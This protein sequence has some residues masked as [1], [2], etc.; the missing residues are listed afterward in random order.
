MSHDARLKVVF[1]GTPDF[2]V[3]VLGALVEAGHDVAGVYTQPDRRAGRGRSSAASPVKRY[4]LAHGLPVLQPASLR[5]DEQA[6]TTLGA[7]APDVVVVAAYGLF[8]PTAMLETP[9]LGCLNIH[10][11]LLPRRRGPSPV[12]SAILEGDATTGVTVI[13]LDDRMD[14]GPIIAQR[15]TPICPHETAGA[16]TA[17]LFRLGAELLL[18]RLPG[19]DRGV[20]VPVD[21]DESLATDTSRLVKQ[22]GE[23][24]WGRPAEYIARQVRAYDPWPGDVHSMG[25]Q[26]PG[27]R[28][29][30]RRTRASR[31]GP[32]R[33]GD[34]VWERGR[35][36]HR[37]GC[38]RAPDGADR[39]SEARYRRRFRQGP[40]RLRR[41]GPRG[42]IGAL[43]P[44]R[45]VPAHAASLVSWQRS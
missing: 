31:I 33:S 1:M 22:D 2:A 35:R 32:C 29:G 24:D 9:R 23:I 4:A 30:L 16:L 45:G 34:G 18:E 27:R 43:A 7:L 42:R 15:R 20:L 13:R 6:A 38:A 12:A 41:F 14:H 40:P 36:R 28:H 21:Q 44:N 26:T 11:S 3:P 8:L 17:R 5:K 37:R 19:L 39:G 25:G 10:P